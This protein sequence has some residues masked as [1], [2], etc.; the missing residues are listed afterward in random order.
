[1]MQ[2]G[3]VMLRLLAVHLWFAVKTMR[4]LLTYVLL[5]VL[6]IRASSQC[7]G[8]INSFPYSE[9][10]EANDG[11][12]VS[13]GV[14]NDW[15]W[16]APNK[17]VIAAAGSGTKCWIV[18]G[19]TG[20]SYASSEASWLQSP[21]FDFTSLQNPY[22]EFKVN[23]EMEQRFDGASFQYSTDNGATWETLGSSANTVTC[24]N[25]NWYNNSSITY[26]APLA[27]NKTGWSGN[28]Q[29]DA[30]TC[31]GGNGSGNWLTAKQGMG[32]LAGQPNVLF[33]F[34]FGSGTIC[35]N[36]DGF[37]I[38][39]I[40][41]K[42]APLYFASFTYTCGPGNVVSFI[43]TSA[44]CMTILN[45]SFSDPASGANNSSSIPN[46]SHQFS[47]PGSYSVV[48]SA[49][50]PGSSVSTAS[51]PVIIPKVTVTQ[52]TPADC[53]ANTGGSLQASAE[54]ITTALNYAWNTNPV[55][56]G[57]VASNLGAGVYTV[58]VSGADVCTTTATGKVETDL[59][60]IG[61]YFPTAFTPDKNGRND[62]FGP[63]G[64]LSSL[65]NYRFSVYNRW[66]EKVFDSP[67]PF[68]K[69]DGKV[70]GY[71]TD[72]NMFLWYAEFSLAGRP[73]ELRKGMILL[74]R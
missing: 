3:T 51:L 29:P 57:Q 15:A 59:S 53:Q 45:W 64:S 17:P 52:L 67:D 63:L 26:L 44:P 54:N 5:I 48:L 27:S 23:W 37:A 70:V 71:K 50:F 22:I 33:R 58:T 73:K 66:G 30:G 31:A 62:G 9:G 43:N 72:G 7:T 68:Q 39:D 25:E 12:W 65:S 36:Y 11:G 56:N 13:G 16:G 40:L 34:I 55:Q 14:G 1:M 49:S 18:G 38:D 32:F 47:G 6:S 35:N 60:C 61:I 4:F 24:Y 2:L 10:F 42:E 74:I 8:G 19:L 46:P 28:I 21:C 41:V 69:W 20:S